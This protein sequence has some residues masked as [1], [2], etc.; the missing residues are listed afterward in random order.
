MEP[1]EGAESDG[2]STEKLRNNENIVNQISCDLIS[3]QA[4][5]YWPKIRE[6][7]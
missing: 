1:F 5:S 2:G 4:S 6:D 7:L 3:M